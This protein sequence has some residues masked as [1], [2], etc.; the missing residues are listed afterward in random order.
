[1][2]CCGAQEDPER[3]I[4]FSNYVML[5]LGLEECGGSILAKNEGREKEP[6]ACG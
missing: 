6:I 2:G 3:A 1:M 4:E 5:V